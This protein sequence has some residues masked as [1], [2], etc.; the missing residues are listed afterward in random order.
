MPSRGETFSNAVYECLLHGLPFIASA[1]GAPAELVAEEDRARVLFEPTAS[2]I[3][4]ALEQV[5]TKDEPLRPASL[6]FDPEE[7]CSAWAEVVRLPAPAR[8]AHAPS[9]LTDEWVVLLGPGDRARDDLVHTLA[10]AQA[11][12]G[13][14]IV[15]CGARLESGLH[16][17]F[18]GDAG[19]LGVLANHYGTTALVRR[20][21]LPKEAECMPRWPLFAGLV[22]AGAKIVS[23]PEALVDQRQDPDDASTSLQV[24][25]LFEH[26]LPRSL[27]LLARLAAGFAAQ[28]SAPA[29]SP[30][31]RFLHR[32]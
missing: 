16:R 32:R 15:T 29:P 21:L 20:S 14:D 31:R 11:A 8:A 6:A 2:G 19:G 24:V 25:H 5:L 30:R 7:A 4:A 1:A 18:V 23:V 10:R 12:S 17:Y 9:E 13:A 3:A 26:H 22:L 28:A 27:R